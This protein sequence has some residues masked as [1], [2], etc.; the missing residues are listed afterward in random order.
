MFLLARKIKSFAVKSVL[1]GEGADETLGGYLYFHK[2]P[3]AAE[4]H[5]ECVRKTSRLHL[6]DVMRAN[7]STLAWGLEARVPFLDKEFL[8]LVMNTRPEDKMIDMVG[9]FSSSGI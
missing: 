9:I 4:Y 1:S 6:W 2:A 7:K 5:R 3:D 8:E